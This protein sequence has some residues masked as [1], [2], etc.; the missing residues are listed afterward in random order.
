M[1][2]VDDLGLL[3]TALEETEGWLNRFVVFPNEH[4]S[5]AV[6]LWVAYTHV[7]EQFDVAPYLLITA[8]EIESG[9]T[10]IMEVAAP[11][12]DAPMFSS[13]MTPAVL[14]RTIDRDHPTLF[15][16]EADNIWAGRR[17]DK[18][19][20]LVALLNAGHRRGVKAQRM[21]GRNRTELEEF[22]VFGPKAIAGAFPDVGNIPEALR[23]RSIH[24]R[25]QRKLPGESV[26]R[27][28]RQT[29]QQTV[30]WVEGLAD[31]LAKYGNE[32]E[33]W[34]Y[35][36]RPIP[37]LSDRDFDIWEPLL[38]IAHAAGGDW[39]AKAH[40][41]AI[42]LC[43]PDPSQATPLRILVLRDLAELW[44]GDAAYMFTGD[45]LEGLHAL[46]D[47]QWSDFYGS[48]LTAHRLAKFLTAYGIESKPAGES[49][50]R[51]YYRQDLDDAWRRYAPET[52]T[53]SEE[54]TGDETS[55]TFETLFDS[56]GEVVVI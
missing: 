37:D 21:G 52:V 20:E 4:G 23:S 36:V 48:P 6:A 12:C 27:W 19:S 45:I 24:L 25:M 22:D 10:R 42:A 9:K 18:A 31:R 28:T 32:A 17:D 40:D 3:D 29:R 33:P 35:T 51:G 55:E 54:T 50:R 26:A 53:A 8:A 43:A 13:S 56:E 11:L 14:F 49:R 7:A 44:D 38:A 16:D 39:P 5:T 30:E 41:A 1:S 46:E 15:L 34:S 47:R 2:V